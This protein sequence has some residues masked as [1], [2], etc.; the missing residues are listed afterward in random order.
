MKD[1]QIWRFCCHSFHISLL[2]FGWLTHATLLISN[3]LKVKFYQT[4]T[5]GGCKSERNAKAA[6]SWNSI[7]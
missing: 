1:S 6:Y 3:E 5:E 4:F 2:N 7:F